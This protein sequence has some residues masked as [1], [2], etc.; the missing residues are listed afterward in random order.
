[1]VARPMRT[2]TF[3]RAHQVQTA[4][5]FRQLNAGSNL[6]DPF[7]VDPVRRSAIAVA[8]C[9]AIV[10]T[11]MLSDH[12]LGVTLMLTVGWLAAVGLVFCVPILIWSAVA[13][14][15]TIIRRRIHPPIE[16]LNLTPRLLHILHRHGF[17]TIVAVDKADDPTLSM[18]ANMDPRDVQQVRRAISLWKYARWQAAGFPATDLP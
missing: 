15:I 13:E 7:S 14:G 17:D 5:T 3:S 16:T 12:E 18:L 8:V 11:P 9:L 2:R 10:L 4:Y 1:V 6:S